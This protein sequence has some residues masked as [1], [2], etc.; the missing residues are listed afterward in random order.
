MVSTYE[1]FGLPVLEAMACGAHVVI[2][3]TPALV[4]IAGEVAQIAPAYDSAEI[5]A[6]IRQAMVKGDR[7]RTAARAHAA[8]FS[9]ERCARETVQ[10]LDAA[11]A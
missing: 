5:A 3:A 9:W 1:G 10:V 11:L 6:A 7:E 2:S 4:E 8:R